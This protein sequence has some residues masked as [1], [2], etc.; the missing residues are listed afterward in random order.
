MEQLGE[1]VNM[2]EEVKTKLTDKE[3]KEL[4]EKTKEI[5]DKKKYDNLYKLKYIKQYLK[6]EF[7]DLNNP[8]H[9]KIISKIETKVVKFHEDWNEHMINSFIE[10][11]GKLERIQSMSFMGGREDISQIYHANSFGD[12]IR[13]DPEAEND[14]EMTLIKFDDIIPL[15]IEE[16]N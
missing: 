15:A 3:Y 12:W 16:L 10:N 7:K 13:S 8:T 4:M 14:E 11:V 9:T 6:N 1:L 2:I 5:N